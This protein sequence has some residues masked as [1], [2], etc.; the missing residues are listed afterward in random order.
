MFISL[1][2]KKMQRFFL[3]GSISLCLTQ[4]SGRT[5][6]RS[7]LATEQRMFLAQD[8]RQQVFLYSALRNGS[9]WDIAV[10]AQFEEISQPLRSSSQERTGGPK[11]GSH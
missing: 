6:Q 8:N 10:G 2:A 11:H 7:A 9:T 4:Q 3:R 1:A 5:V